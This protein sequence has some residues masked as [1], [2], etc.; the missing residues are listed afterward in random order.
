M[1]Q[2]AL[3]KDG[4]KHIVTVPV[5]L[6]Q[7]QDIERPPQHAGKGFPVRLKKGNLT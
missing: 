5:H 4:R 7:M 3:S 1:S 2:H 6:R